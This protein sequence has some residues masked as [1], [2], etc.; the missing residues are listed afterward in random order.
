MTMNKAIEFIKNI[1]KNDGVVI[2]FNND[3]DGI[4][5]CALFMKYLKKIG[6]E[7]YIINQPMPLDQNIIKRIQTSLPNK[8]VFLDMAVDQQSDIVKKLKGIADIL[9]IDH[10]QIYKDLNSENVVH[11]NPRLENPKLYQSTTYLVY[12]LLSEIDDYSNYLWIAAAGMISDYNL[13]DSKDVVEEIRKAYSVK[14]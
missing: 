2:I 14:E 13:E 4:C 10:H 9:V 12:K 3:G 5:S 7:P 1:G 6:N 11:H 8:I